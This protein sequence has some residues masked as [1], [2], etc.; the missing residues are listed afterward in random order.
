MPQ[1]LSRISRMLQPGGAVR[2]LFPGGATVKEKAKKQ[3]EETTEVFKKSIDFL[4]ARELWTFGAFR[5][6]QERMLQVTGGTGVKALLQ[7]ENEVVKRIKTNIRILEAMNVYELASNHKDVFT[8]HSKR[9]IAEKANVTLEAV[10]NLIREHDMLRADRRWYK[11]RK[12]FNRPLPR[13]AEEREVLA[14]RDRPLSETE[15]EILKSESKKQIAK[16]MNKKKITQPSPVQGL[17]FRHPSKGFD[18]W[19]VVPPRSEPRFSSPKIH[20]KNRL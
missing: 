17:Y 10:D 6:Y 18:R 9:L 11:I 3:E 20:V 8:I 4:M 5:H 1:L 2:R 12:Q 14:T 15:K 19:R 7:G 13:T 16:H